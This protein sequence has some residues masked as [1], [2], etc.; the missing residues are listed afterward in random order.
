M[1]SLKP[2]VLCADDYA[3]NEGVSRAIVQLATAG[4]LSATSVMT[5]SPHWPDHAPWLAPL[6]GRIDVGLHLDWTSSFALRA[7]HGAPLGTVMRRAV[8]GRISRAEALRCIRVQLDAFEQVWG[9]P[10]DHVDGHQHVQQFAGIREA[11]VEELE[12]RYTGPR[13]Y[14]RL[15]RP[16]PGQGGLKGR[17]MAA[18]GASRLQARARAAGVPCA[19]WLPG[20]DDF[21]TDVAAY[22]RSMANWLQDA[23]AA[24]LIMCH[25]A[26]RAEADDEIGAARV[27]EWT[28]FNSP[29]FAQAMA[30]AGVRLASGQTLYS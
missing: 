13:P 12:R 4:R 25:P 30:A 10:P 29:D 5:L 11:L 17:I 16:L 3:L 21:S 27:R 19:S 23:P 8:L 18:M 20:I 15:S 22:S 28:Y 7:G 24:T 9:A 26:E 1:V 14:L 6:R 2:V